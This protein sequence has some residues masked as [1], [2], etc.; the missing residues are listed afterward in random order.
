MKHQDLQAKLNS[1]INSVKIAKDQL[2]KNR[3]KVRSVMR[4]RSAN[5]PPAKG[6]PYI[7]AQSDVAYNN[8]P[9]G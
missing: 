6:I 4:L 5:G 3:E 9:K 8:P 1:A 7:R 2:K